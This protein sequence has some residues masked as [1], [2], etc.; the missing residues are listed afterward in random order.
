MLVAFRG[1]DSVVAVVVVIMLLVLFP[2]PF[3]CYFLS[4]AFD[5]RVGAL[6]ACFGGTHDVYEMQ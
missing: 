1:D 2:L 5:G 6:E 4:F 3:C